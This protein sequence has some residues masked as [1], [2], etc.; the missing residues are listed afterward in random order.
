MAD[1][2]EVVTEKS[3]DVTPAGK[4]VVKEKTQVSSSEQEK[5]QTVSVI[6]NLVFFI[7]SV[8]EVFLIFRL[9]LKVLGANPGSWFVSFIY[10]VSGLFEAPFR[11]IF[12]TAVSEGIE[13]RS[14]FEPSTLVAVIV[15]V[16]LAFGIVELIKVVT[17]HKE[18]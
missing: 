9:V 12:R 2:Q 17:S 18:E 4:Q 16:V 11:G 8:I 15:Y 14:V 3:V 1:T 7:A 5:N 10:S 13:I 6:T